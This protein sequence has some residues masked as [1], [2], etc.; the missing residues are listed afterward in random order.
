MNIVILNWRD[1]EHPLAGGAEQSLFNH[2]KYWQKKGA[3]ILWISSGFANAKKVVDIKGIKTIRLG[4]HYT[5]H[6]RAAFMYAKLKNSDIVIDSFHFLPFF[7]PLYERKNKIIAL[8]NEPG[9]NAWF[10][11]IFFP[12]S[13][14]GYVVEPFFFKLYKKI[15]FLT[16][17]ASI[18]EELIELG[19]HEKNLHIVP[20]GVTIKKT[21]R[22]FKRNITPTIIYLS[23]V[24][25]DKGIEDGIK[26]VKIL[27]EKNTDLKFWIVGKS[28]SKE[29]EKK[30]KSLIKSEKITKNTTYFGFVTED[31]KFELL[32]KA[33]ILIHPSIREGWGLNVIEANTFSTPA[34]GYNVSGLRDSIQNKKTGLLT[35]LNT[36][37][38]LAECCL[39]LISDKTMLDKLSKN[40]KNWAAKFSWE[41]AGQR[42]WELVKKIYEKNK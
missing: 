6:L 22:P 32:Q 24:S 8:I 28:I 39:R 11:N 23:Q 33:W 38:A 10:E 31:K 40:A 21:L 20:H 4:S 18:K 3:N 7:T 42:S 1:I 36:P 13:L 30:I 25:P 14:I 9:K 34:V 29:Y 17:S 37:N 27:L 5:V 26:A 12:V 35:E 16:S 2:A 15:P 19:I 41:K